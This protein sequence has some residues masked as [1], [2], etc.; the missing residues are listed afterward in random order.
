MAA[1]KTATYSTSVADLNVDNK[2]IAQADDEL[3]HAR[4]AAA[5]LDTQHAE[6]QEY[7]R[8]I[9]AGIESGKIDP[10]GDDLEAADKRVEALGLAAAGANRRVRE[11]L[12][13]GA[14]TSTDLLSAVEHGLTGILPGVTTVFGIGAPPAEA[15]TELTL[16]VLWVA[17]E[18]PHG[19]AYNGHNHPS[20]TGAVAG[21]LTVKYYRNESHRELRESDIVSA[22]ASHD[23]RYDV[24]VKVNLT[25][26]ADTSDSFRVRVLHAMPS[27]PALPRTPNEGDKLTS[28]PLG[29]VVNAVDP[30]GDRFGTVSNG[31]ESL[32]AIAVDHG[33]TH[34]HV[35]A[36][37]TNGRERVATIEVTG[38]ILSPHGQVERLADAI[39]EAAPAALVGQASQYGRWRSVS[40]TTA[41]EHGASEVGVKLTIEATSAA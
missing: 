18:K 1:K 39:E 33:R 19:V 13:R 30:R 34:G 26:Q 5:R 17:Q 29:A 14:V 3:R 40:A 36:V 22:L 9:R 11:T 27:L 23:H 7:A 41:Y 35:T 6:A 20:M 31:F 24:P 37:T 25:R 16:P 8:D 10:T 28:P 2:A 32:R 21:D 12:N 4:E 38:V 15:P